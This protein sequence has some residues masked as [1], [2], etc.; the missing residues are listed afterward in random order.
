MP[1]HFPGSARSRRHD[2]GVDIVKNCD[3]LRDGPVR[4]FTNLTKR[5]GGRPPYPRVR[6]AER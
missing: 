6:I 5:I 1:A 3:Q 4:F 2:T